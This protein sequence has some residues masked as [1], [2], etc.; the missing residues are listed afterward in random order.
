MGVRVCPDDSHLRIAGRDLGIGSV[1][2]PGDRI[3][4]GC[5]HDCQQE[6]PAQDNDATLNRRTRR[7]RWILF[8]SDFILNTVTFDNIGFLLFRWMRRSFFLRDSAKPL[9]V[10]GQLIAAQQP[11]WITTP[12]FPV[13]QAQQQTRMQFNP[14]RIGIN[15]C[16]ERID[17]LD[18]HH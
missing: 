8:A 5:R 11:A 7:S 15:G 6:E 16:Q 17:C 1:D 3:S 9:L 12:A 4:Q 13:A 10:L 14:L 18:R 2:F